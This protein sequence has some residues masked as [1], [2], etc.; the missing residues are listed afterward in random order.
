ME[1]IAIERGKFSKIF[2]FLVNNSEIIEEK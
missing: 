1:K 2:E